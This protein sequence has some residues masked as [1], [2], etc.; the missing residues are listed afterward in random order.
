MQNL[1]E[2]HQGHFGEVRFWAYLF[3]SSVFYKVTPYVIVIHFPIFIHSLD[4]LEIYIFQIYT[5][6]KYKMVQK[7]KYS[8]LLCHLTTQFP[9]SYPQVTTAISVLC[10]FTSFFIQI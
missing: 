2:A 8:C 4:G 1:E 9:I 6:N 10:V 5:I 7:A 3:C